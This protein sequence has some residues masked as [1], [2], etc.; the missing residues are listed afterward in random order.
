[1]R[2]IAY[3]VLILGALAAGEP[4]SAFASP[5]PPRWNLE[6][7]AARDNADYRLYRLDLAP[8][9]GGTAMAVMATGRGTAID[10]AYV[11][12]NGLYTEQF[13]AEQRA[14]AGRLDVR[15]EL[16]TGYRGLDGTGSVNGKTLSL[17]LTLQA[18]AIGGTWRLTGKDAAA[19]AVAGAVTGR[20]LDQAALARENGV[21][22]DLSWAR[23]DGTGGGMAAQ[24]AGCR[25]VDD[26]SQARLVWFSEADTWHGRETGDGSDK[27]PAPKAFHITGSYS[28]PV[29]AD[30]RVFFY[31]YIPRGERLLPL[32]STLRL[33]AAAQQKW[34]VEAD[35]VVTCMD[36][37][38]GATVWRQVMRGR[39]LNWH[40]GNKHATVNMT[41]CVDGRRLYAIGSGGWAFGFDAV[42]GA[43]LW[44]SKVPGLFEQLAPARTGGAV[45]YGLEEY[46]A[47]AEGVALLLGN[48]VVAFDGATGAVLWKRPGIATTWMHAGRTWVL[49]GAGNRLE[50]LDPKTGAPAW[51]ATVEADIAD[52]YPMTVAGDHALLPTGAAADRPRGVV[53]YRLAPSGATLAWKGGDDLRFPLHAVS[54]MAAA[55]GLAWLRPP[56]TKGAKTGS[57]VAFEVATGRVVAR[58]DDLPAEVS[59]A[60]AFVADGRLFS[61]QDRNHGMASQRL[62]QFDARTM[63]SIGPRW[64]RPPH[65]TTSGY[66]LPM[67]MPIVDGRWFTR[68]MGAIFCFDLRRRD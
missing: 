16:V 55:D 11:Q 24:P 6:P 61:D 17:A 57:L 28:S 49:V 20:V 13:P 44:E 45:R 41:P 68:G 15:F 54:G 14:A 22:A 38:S 63:V 46:F 47:A 1:M 33:D 25:L 26:L 8:Q 64:G 62:L 35:D 32:A 60:L 59:N 58:R 40:A 23:W 4:E 5:F 67:T 66:D 48:G 36:A 56:K 19:P 30:G 39:G 31:A 27:A 10:R 2:R 42:S 65:P 21:R 34:A 7:I 52:C 29:V 37:A 9:G 43:V 53:G 3:A 51:T 12:V 18:G 50:C